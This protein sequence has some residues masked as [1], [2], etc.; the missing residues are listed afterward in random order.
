MREAALAMIRMARVRGCT[1]LVCGSDATD[2]AP[3]YLEAGAHF[4]LAGEGEATLVELM[5]RLGG[6]SETAL[7]AIPGLVFR[8]A[9]G[10]L[11]RTA[12]RPVMR[13]LDALPMPA[14]DLVDVGRYREIWLRRH[15]Y[16]SMNMVTT[17]GCPYHCNWCAKPIWGQTYNSR[18][19]TWWPSCDQADLPADH[20]WFATTSWA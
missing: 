19:E 10:G 7:D 2:Q 12:A 3:V 18:P 1:V 20:V 9:D 15:G 17:R 4:V 11:V 16:F 14:W 8:G 13:D 6:R 5:D